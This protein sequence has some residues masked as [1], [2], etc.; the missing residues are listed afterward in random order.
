MSPTEVYFKIQSKWDH[1]YGY[2]DL[3]CSGKC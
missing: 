2:V 1:Y 3:R